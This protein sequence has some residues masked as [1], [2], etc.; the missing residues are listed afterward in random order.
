MV[1]DMKNDI[2]EKVDT[3]AQWHEDVEDAYIEN[4][5]DSKVFR[6]Y[7]KGVHIK[8]YPLTLFHKKA[9]GWEYELYS[10]QRKIDWDSLH[11]TA[12]T[13]ILIDN[14]GDHAHSSEQA[15]QWAVRTV[16]EWND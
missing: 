1:N 10:E 14:V 9:L 2:N 7:H 15:M 6:T 11:E 3:Q 8:V 12:N 13:G 4:G 5:K 16:D